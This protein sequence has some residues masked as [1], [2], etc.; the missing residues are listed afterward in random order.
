LN[1]RGML[2]LIGGGEEK[3]Q[4]WSD[5]L[6]HKIVNFSNNGS[7]AVI[8]D[9][10]DQAWME[11]YFRWLGAR[12]ARTFVLQNRKEAD[13]PELYQQIQ[14]FDAL[15]LEGGHQMF[16]YQTWKNTAFEKAL[17]DFYY[18][19]KMISGT[20]AAAMLLGEVIFLSKNGR[21]HPDILYQN[22]F[23]QSILLK[24][25]FLNLIPGT[26]IDSHFTERGRLLRLIPLMAR[27]AVQL[28]KKITGIGIDEETALMIDSNLKGE[29]FGNR[30]VIVLKPTTDSRIR[31]EF[32]K[33]PEFTHLELHSLAAGMRYDFQTHQIINE[34]DIIKNIKK[35]IP[36]PV[37]NKMVFIGVQSLHVNNEITHKIIENLYLKSP[38][39]N[40]QLTIIA[41]QSSQEVA[42]DF[43]NIIHLQKQNNVAILPLHENKKESLLQAPIVKKST[44]IVL[45]T[46]D[47]EEMLN[48][49]RSTLPVAKAFRNCVKSGVTLAF[50]S[51]A[52][53]LAGRWM[54]PD[55]LPKDNFL[56]SGASVKEG[57][58]YL[59]NAIL[60]P[61][62]SEN[63]DNLPHKIKLP[64]DAGLENSAGLIILMDTQSSFI[65][66]SRKTLR[67]SGATPTLVIDLTGVQKSAAEKALGWSNAVIHCMHDD[68]AFDLNSYEATLT[69]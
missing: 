44:G 51:S 21:V 46:H 48:F 59:K 32:P 29:V 63:R 7:I 30:N 1:T 57:L 41:N 8:S 58:N 39:E 53:K 20:S 25:D 10:D 66:Q 22:P 18:T 36:R 35:K 65:S 12:D 23:L 64:I 55:S 50:L 27:C 42:Q 28:N 38:D 34:T 15:F 17:L 3:Y 4:S 37:K 40:S 5:S 45:A 49:L 16:Y 26:M 19:G 11:N 52:I 6:Y 54:L 61:N 9:S 31:F 33:P 24:D 43:E 60:S 2:Y 68:C 13:S 47:N 67:F 56:D 69:Y 62:L 14:K